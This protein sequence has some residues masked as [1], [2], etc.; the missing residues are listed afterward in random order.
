MSHA[1][2][3]A[4]TLA[5][6]LAASSATGADGYEVAL[7]SDRLETQDTRFLGFSDPNDLA[8]ILLGL[9]VSN[10]VLIIALGVVLYLYWIIRM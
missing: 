5:K 8:W 4:K 6:V 9:I 10:V 2:A 1:R 3:A 7:A